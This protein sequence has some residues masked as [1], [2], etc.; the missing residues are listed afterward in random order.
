MVVFPRQH[1][2]WSHGDTGETA[3]ADRSNLLAFAEFFSVHSDVVIEVTAFPESEF[4]PLT[5][6]PHEQW[7]RH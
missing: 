4:N 6:P 1:L 7:A 3:D 2:I 5:Q